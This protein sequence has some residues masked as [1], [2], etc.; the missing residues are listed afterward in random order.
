MKTVTRGNEM[1]IFLEGKSLALATAHTLTVSA[2]TVD[3]STKDHGYWKASDVGNMSFEV[4]SENLY[5][6]DDFNM[7]FDAML[8]KTPLTL[9]WGKAKDYNEN[10]LDDS[11]DYWD[12]PLSDY[13][14]GQAVLTS[15]TQNANTGENVTYSATFTGY[16]AIERVDSQ[17]NTPGNP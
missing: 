6:D 8:Q 17:S 4:T 3:I 2:D 16:G 7:L 15:L 12:A 14:T 9:V 10:G 11:D 1:M 5:V 13:Y